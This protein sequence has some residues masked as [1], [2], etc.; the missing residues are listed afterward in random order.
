GNY[1]N[2]Q[3]CQCED[4]CACPE[5]PTEWK[6]Y[7]ATLFAD[8]L[9]SAHYCLREYGRLREQTQTFTDALFDATLPRD[10]IDA[11]SANLAI[12]KSPT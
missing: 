3:P 9:D 6:Q 7:Y 5:D 2:P 11:I 8:A 12:V 10:A 4:G 1:W